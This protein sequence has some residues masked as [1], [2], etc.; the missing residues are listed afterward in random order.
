MRHHKQTNK[1]KYI[2]PTCETYQMRTCHLMDISAGASGFE[3]GGELSKKHEFDNEHTSDSY[4][5]TWETDN[6]QIGKEIKP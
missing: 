3:Y 1:R 2:A 4:D 5:F 6:S